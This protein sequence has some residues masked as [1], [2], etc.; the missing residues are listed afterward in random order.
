MNL[1]RLFV[2]LIAVLCLAGSARSDVIYN[3]RFDQTSLTMNTG[4]SVTLNVYFEETVT[5]GSPHRL[6]LSAIGLIDGSFQ[7]A[8]SGTGTSTSTAATGNAGFDFL[9]AI[10]AGATT[11]VLQST[12]LNNPVLATDI[13]GGTF[14]VQLGTITVTAGNAGDANVLTLASHPVNSI[15]I[16]DGLGGATFL[17]NNG[18]P[19]FGSVNINVSAVPEPSLGLVGLLAAGGA[20]WRRR[21]NETLLIAYFLSLNFFVRSDRT[22]K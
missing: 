10:A 3:I 15:T 17:V 4:A 11:T 22:K 7:A 1:G 8:I 9:P 19:I 2:S 14:R 16:D 21:K 12:V 5:S 20:A 18:N 6:D 13:G